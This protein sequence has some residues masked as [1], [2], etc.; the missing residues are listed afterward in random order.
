MVSARLGTSSSSAPRV[1]LKLKLGCEDVRGAVTFRVPSLPKEEIMDSGLTPEGRE[2]RCSNCL[3]T[4]LPP[5]SVWVSCLAK[6][7]RTSPSV[8]TLNSSGCKKLDFLVCRCPDHKADP[9][10]VNNNHF[11]LKTGK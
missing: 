4:K 6:I 5:D 3:D 7:T 9:K 11:H 10:F 1:F 8:F 2:N